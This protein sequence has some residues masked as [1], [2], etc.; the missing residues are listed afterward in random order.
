MTAWKLATVDV[1]G[2]PRAAIV[3]GERLYDLAGLASLRGVPATLLG[4]LDRWAEWEPRLAEAA[5]RL[6]ADPEAE[7]GA[8]LGPD[9]RLRAP[10]LYPR[11]VLCAGANYGKHVREMGTQPP[12][13]SKTNPYF[14]LKPPTTTVIGPGEPIRIPPNSRE[15]DWEV[16]LAAVIGRTAKDVPVERAGE[17]VAGY[18]ILNDISARDIHRREDWG[19][20][21]PFYWDWLQ[22]KGCDTFAPM[23][24]YLVP[25]RQVANVYKLRLTLAV[26]GTIQQDANTDDLIFNVEEQIAYLSTMFTLEP[27]DVIATGTPSGVGK[28]RGLFLHHGD[29]VVAE[30]EQIGSL[31]NPVV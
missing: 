4:V 8:A 29:E 3:L 18:T 1:R 12:Y 23:G 26:N 19:K 9:A 17:H 27:G 16:E 11:K 2:E 22:S 21:G 24:P 28:P 25:R 6:G 10:I 13:K 20:D 31:R 15:V 30:I 5:E 7:P 14:F